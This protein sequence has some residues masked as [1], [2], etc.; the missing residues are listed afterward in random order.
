[1]Y[2]KLRILSIVLM[3]IFSTFAVGSVN[4]YCQQKPK[5]KVE[6]KYVGSKKSTVYH[7]PTCKWAKKIKD[8]NLI[9]DSAD[10]KKHGSRP[11]KVCKP[12]RKKK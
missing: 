12:L 9:K 11:C 10:A 7:L 3:L 2:R 8:S 4:I 5:Q 1:M 6:Y